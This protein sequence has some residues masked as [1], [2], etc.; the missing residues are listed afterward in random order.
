MIHSRRCGMSLI[1]ILAALIIAAT[2]ATLGIQYLRPAGATGKQRSCDM[3]REVLQVDVRRHSELTGNLPSQ[4]LREIAS[5]PYASTGLP[6]CPVSGQDY[7]LDRSG[8]VI[9]PVHETTRAK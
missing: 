3:T 8:T 9:C 6:N 5:G 7:R 1:E 4:D 2:V